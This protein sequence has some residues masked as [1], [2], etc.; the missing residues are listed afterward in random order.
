MKPT[1]DG[2]IKFEAGVSV[3]KQQAIPTLITVCFCPPV[4]LAQIWGMIKQTKLDEKA[5]EIAERAV[6]QSN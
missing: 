4:V 6:Y 1:K 2:N 3:L 5:V